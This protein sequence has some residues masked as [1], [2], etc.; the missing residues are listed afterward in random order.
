[1]NAYLLIIIT[2]TLIIQQSFSQIKGKYQ[3]LWAIFHPIAAIQV[4]HIYKKNYPIYLQVKQEKIID[5]IENG[6]KLDAFRHCFFMACF[7]QKIKS[8]KLKSLSIAH[9]KDD[10]YI[11]R[12]KKKHEY[13]DIP[14]SASIE[15]DLYNNTIGIELGK[16][17]KNLSTN[18]LKDTVIKYIRNNKVKIIL[19]QPKI[20]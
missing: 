1:M 6:G 8:K 15:M 2:S 16:K 17:Y 18:Q 3:Y 12:K 4:K 11:Y 10:L 13:N 7:A 14:D 20:M 5:T 19:H 9:E